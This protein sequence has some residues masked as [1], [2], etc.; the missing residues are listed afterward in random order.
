MDKKERWVS[1]EG[2]WHQLKHKIKRVKT[3]LKGHAILEPSV[4]AFDQLFPEAAME[5]KRLPEK[6]NWN[7]CREGKKNIVL[8]LERE[9]PS[10]LH[11][12]KI[13]APSFI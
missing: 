2:S 13:I 10:I 6:T 3:F 7:S 12:L 9:S 4:V 11:I 5:A 1:R 8:G